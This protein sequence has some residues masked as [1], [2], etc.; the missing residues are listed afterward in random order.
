M[1]LVKFSDCILG[2]WS[3][4]SQISKQ[5]LYRVYPEII[6]EIVKKQRSKTP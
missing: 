5:E 2:P 1:M 4:G 6:M 3:R